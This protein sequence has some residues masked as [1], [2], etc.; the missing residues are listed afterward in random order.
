MG[1]QSLSDRTDDIKAVS[2]MKISG[3]VKTAAWFLVRNEALGKRRT[4]H[5]SHRMWPG[6]IVSAW[7]SRPRLAE[8]A[9]MRKASLIESCN[10]DD[11][12]AGS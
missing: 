12:C 10:D 7:I 1:N 4:P 2:G 6:W 5:G 9:A 8:A 11:R 3:G